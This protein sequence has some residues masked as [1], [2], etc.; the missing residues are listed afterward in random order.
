MFVCVQNDATIGWKP[1]NI[2][3]LLSDVLKGSGFSEMPK[4][5]KGYKALA[6]NRII[7]QDGTVV[8]AHFEWGV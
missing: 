3:L 1:T 2:C 8:Y 6:E 5:R 7:N 4:S